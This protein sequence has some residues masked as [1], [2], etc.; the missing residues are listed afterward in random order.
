MKWIPDA[1]KRSNAKAGEHLLV[2]GDKRHPSTYHTSQC[3]CSGERTRNIRSHVRR[4]R[5]QREGVTWNAA[6]QWRCSH[7]QFRDLRAAPSSPHKS[8]IAAPLEAG[9]LR[10]R[11][12]AAGIMH[13]VRSAEVQTD[14]AKGGSVRPRRRRSTAGESIWMRAPLPPSH[15]R[16]EK[17]P[18][19]LFDSPRHWLTV[20]LHRWGERP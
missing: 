16:W 8:K 12:S 20:G 9:G 3:L 15:R 6:L 13:G 10:K 5:D 17:R 11:A 1:I 14:D 4:E 7:A 2:G 19:M 18:F